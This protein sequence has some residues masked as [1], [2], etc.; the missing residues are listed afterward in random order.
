[1]AELVKAL[2]PAFIGGAIT[3][4]ISWGSMKTTVRQLM[5]RVYLLEQCIS[6]IHRSLGRIEGRLEV[7]G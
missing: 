6:G 5:K 3:G 7:K 2:L 1:M 4:L